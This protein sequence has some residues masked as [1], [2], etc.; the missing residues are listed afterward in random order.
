M[1]D[2]D[3]GSYSDGSIDY[4]ESESEEDDVDSEA[5]KKPAHDNNDDED[6]EASEHESG[7]DTESLIG[8]ED[9][10]IAEVDDDNEFSELLATEE[11]EKENSVS[12]ASKQ[13]FGTIGTPLNSVIRNIEGNDGAFTTSDIISTFEYTRLL[14]Y[15]KDYM[16]IH[17]HNS[18]DIRKILAES[19]DEDAAADTYLRLGKLPFFIKREVNGKF[20][21]IPHH[22][23]IFKP[24]AFYK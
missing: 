18:Q 13:L 9:L 3:E 23:L 11:E 22:K 2:D 1:A 16:R 17:F 14:S 19:I 20:E 5:E 15:T 10:S 8:V 12:V 4:D 21:K 6:E 24:V 7:T